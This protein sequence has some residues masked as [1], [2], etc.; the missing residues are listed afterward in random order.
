MA[1]MKVVA[2]RTHDDGNLDLDDL[3]AKAEQYKDNLAAFMVCLPHFS[4]VRSERYFCVDHIP[5][6]FRR[7]R[8]RRAGC[9]TLL[10]TSD[11]SADL[12]F[13]RRAK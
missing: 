6:D 12:K 3:K 11:L 4:L 5:I 1:G 7:V 8:G 10:L 2:V 9:T 13:H